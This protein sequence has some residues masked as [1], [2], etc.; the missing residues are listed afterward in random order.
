MKIRSTAGPFATPPRA[1]AAALAVAL[2]FSL[3]EAL[4]LGFGVPQISSTLGEPLRM[5]IPLRVDPGI[6]LTSQCVRLVPNAEGDDLPALT[7]A[8]A[9]LTLEMNSD[10]PPA[11]RIDSASPINEP[12]LHVTVEAGC[13]QRVQRQ[14]TL[15]LDP[16]EYSPQL[17]LALPPAQVAATQAPANTGTGAPEAPPAVAATLPQPPATPMPAPPTTDLE[18]GNAQ[19]VGRVGQPLSMQIPIF[20]ARSA[21]LDPNCVRLADALSGDGAPV[22]NQANLSLAHV[23]TETTLQLVTPQPVTEPAVRV[24]LEV[25][26]EEPMRREYSVLLD[27]PAAPA[28]APLADAGPG[29][30]PAQPTQTPAPVP[31]ADAGPGMQ[32]AQPM[33]TAA[34]P[35]LAEAGPAMPAAVAAPVKPE[36]KTTVHRSNAPATASASP[37]R[38]ATAAPAS[39]TRAST[40]V[41]PPPAPALVA[42]SATPPTPATEQ[43]PAAQIKKP[44]GA[45]D[46]LVIA[47]VEDQPDAGAAR[48]AEMEKRVDGLRKELRQLRA[49]LDT[50]KQQRQSEMD[51]YAHQVEFAWVAAIL[52]V[53]GVGIGGLLSW[54]RRTPRQKPEVSRPSWDTIVRTADKPPPT[55][56]PMAKPMPREDL[57]RSTAMMAQTPEGPVTEPGAGAFP[58]NA[59]HT[60]IEVTE[61]HDSAQSIEQLYTL[62]HDAGENALPPAAA[63]NTEGLDIDLNP[64]KLDAGASAEAASGLGAAAQDSHDDAPTFGPAQTQSPTEIALDLDLTTRVVPKPPQEPSNTQV[65]TEI[66]PLDLD[67]TT[68]SVPPTFHDLDLTARS[69]PPVSRDLVDLTARAV[70]PAT[71]ELN[72]TPRP[73]PA[74]S[75]DLGPPA[76]SAPPASQ[77]LDQSAHSV[78]PAS[79]SLG[80]TPRSAPPTSRDHDEPQTHAPTELSLDLDLTTRVVPPPPQDEPHTQMPATEMALDL[81]LTTRIVP[82]P[83]PLEEPQTEMPATEMALDLDLT[84]RVVPDSEAPTNPVAGANNKPVL[85]TVPKTK[86]GS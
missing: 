49:E 48:L 20:G 27:T 35:P 62:F 31:L 12:V 85:R 41:V 59:P 17:A 56:M 18:L 3:P 71:R 37:A 53:I 40:A 54:K 39:A 66:A 24:V 36:H 43:E 64:S 68:R 34:P 2:A 60:R 75:R 77:G 22:L 65:P 63:P 21:A 84:T 79:Q 42:T 72:L 29:M 55:T 19:I 81:D 4:A 69:A 57:P 61:L 70:P 73:V 8:T 47:A 74:A 13:L 1:A 50:E 82:A 52:G 33:E 67:L 86:T 26:C 38:A 14:F 15:L 10:Q 7:M 16:P 9:R 80:L 51:A 28:P 23:G 6:E 30:Q 78:P 45:A 44:A 83:P 32:P 25:G 58:T 46:H 5:R 11:L 76:R